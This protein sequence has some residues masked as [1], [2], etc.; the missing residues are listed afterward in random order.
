M[1]RAVAIAFLAAGL[2]LAHGAET[3]QGVFGTWGGLR[4]ALSDYGVEFELSYINES[5]ANVS[6]GA[7]REAA[8]AD[9]IFLGGSLDLNRLVSVPGAKII[10]SITD[11]NGESLSTKAGLNTQLEVQE[12]Y[13]EG[14]YTRLNQLYWQQQLF[15]NKVLLKFGRLTGTFDFMPFSCDFQNI[16]FCATIPSHGVVE[17]WIAFPGDTWAGVARFNLERDWY[18][19]TGVYEVNPDFQEHK[20]RFAFGTPFGG[21][22]TREVAEVGWLPASAGSNGGYRLGAWYDNVGGDDLYLNTAGQPLATNG[23]TP[24]Q[25]HHQSGF[26]AMVQQQLWTPAEDIQV[27]AVSSAPAPRPR[28][29][30]AERRGLSVFMN[31]MQADPRITAKQQIVSVG[32]F[33]TGPFASRPQDDLGV[34]IGRTH[35][36]NLVA[37]GEALYNAEVALPSGLPLQPIQHSEYPI[38]VY[39]C[40]KVTPAVELHPNVQII[41]APGGVNERTDVVLF[42]LH[43]AVQF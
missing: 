5:A 17:N 29:R 1:M 42:G 35:V 4:T 3:P 25:R 7:S 30:T 33:W 9:Q 36:N 40:I 39:Y 14:N 43:L 38:E 10:F 24:L 37:Q 12:I 15:D 16:S 32:L 23:G 28:P 34:A 6:G 8:S 21:Q 27:P 26:Y 18:V 22:G 13:G 19:Q 2:G 31:F 20:Y 11:R 41:H